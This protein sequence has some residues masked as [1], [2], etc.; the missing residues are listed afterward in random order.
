MAPY[1]YFASVDSL[2][3]SRGPLSRTL[4]PATIS[5]V[6]KAVMDASKTQR[7]KPRG[8]YAK[9][10]PEQQAKIGKLLRCMEIQLHYIAFRKSWILI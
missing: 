6:N 5:D 3:S 8:K 1:R 2:P 9:L 7:S 10:T 4:S